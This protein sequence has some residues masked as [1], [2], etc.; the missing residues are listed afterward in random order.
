M[1]IRKLPIATA[2][3]LLTGCGGGAP[4][5][6][7]PDTV[8]PRVAFVRIDVNRDNVSIDAADA[9]LHDI[10]HELAQLSGLDVSAHDSL[11]ETLTL[12]LRQLPLDRALAAILQDRNY[13]LAY[14]ARDA[15]SLPRPEMLYVFAPNS[16]GSDDDIRPALIDT[17]VNARIDAVEAVGN[18]GD[19]NAI[20]LLTEA[21]LDPALDVREAA[22]EALGT[23]GGPQSASALGAALNDL[24]A[25]MREEA[26][27][28]LG[29]I[30]G[31][32]SATLLELA[33]LDLDSSVRE[34]AEEQLAKLSS[35]LPLH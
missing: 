16:P 27:Y 23:I 5:I 1:S 30:G 18:V 15:R 31:S 26:V 2:L 19:Q 17:D 4:V 29:H 12:E 13:T 22:I 21:L 32:T 3:C 7:E 34:A 8:A 6:Q 28:A 11:A 20:A 9:T 24:D 35:K 33:L 25:S 10:L 14:R